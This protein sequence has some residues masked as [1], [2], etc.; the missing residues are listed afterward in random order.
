MKPKTF[1]EIL[2]ASSIGQGLE[3]I[4]RNGLASELRNME[5]ELRPPKDR[6][7]VTIRRYRWRY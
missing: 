4:K 1:K 2:A 5:R 3:N 7:G 6:D